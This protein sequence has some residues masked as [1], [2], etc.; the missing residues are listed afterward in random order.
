MQKIKTKIISVLILILFIGLAFA[1]PYRINTKQIRHGLAQNTH[2]SD[3]IN[4]LV[5]NAFLKEHFPDL[6]IHGG[7]SNLSQIDCRA[8]EEDYDIFFRFLSILSGKDTP[9]NMEYGTYTVKNPQ[10]IC[11]PENIELAKWYE[12]HQDEIN[13]EVF[14]DY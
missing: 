10:W 5:L 14:Y 7:P 9:F 6:D 2:A 3:T 11:L 13:W 8:M 12:I 4:C 1:M